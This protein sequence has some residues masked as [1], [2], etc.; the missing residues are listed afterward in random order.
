[1]TSSPTAATSAVPSRAGADDL[2][3]VDDLG[4]GD[5]L[6]DDPDLDEEVDDELIGLPKDRPGAATLGFAIWLLIAGAV[7]GL[8]A[9]ILS[10]DKVKL[11]EN[12]D[13]HFLCSVNRFV[14]CGSVMATPQASE[15]GFPNSFLGVAGFAIVLAVGTG[16]LAGAAYR[17]WFW[18]GLQVGV[19]GGIALVCWLIDQSLFHIGALCPYCMVVWTVMIPTFLAVTAYNLRS[20]HL[21]SAGVGAGRLLTRHLGVVVVIAY[22]CVLA[23]IGYKFGVQ[24]STYGF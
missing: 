17:R 10:W 2:D 6:I 15:F 20:G 5:D 3:P 23:L 24:P 9:F 4:P 21:G 8:A 13:A 11:L 16:L 14:N 7:G 1:M 12:P 18:L 22:G 19:I